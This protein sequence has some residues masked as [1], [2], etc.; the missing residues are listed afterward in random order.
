MVRLFLAL[1]FLFSVPVLA[2]NVDI[3]DVNAE[4]EGST[5]IEIH[6]GEKAKE[7]AQK[8]QPNWE[9][10]DG[11]AEIEGEPAS[12]TREARSQWR[13]ACDSWKKD[14]RADNKDSKII[15]LNCGTADCSGDA[16]QK[17]CSSK[18]SYKIKTKLD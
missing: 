12:M 3:K 14:F 10:V 4:G 6:R 5:T 15:S 1:A 7:K 8:C 18:A 9:V 11:Q 13:K 17:I 16:T 2:Q